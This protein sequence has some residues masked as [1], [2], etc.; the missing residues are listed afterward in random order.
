MPLN[1]GD[2]MR[3]LMNVFL[4]LSVGVAT[5]TS[6][7]FRSSHEAALG[8]GELS[9]RL[10]FDDLDND[11]D[12]LV[13][14]KDSDCCWACLPD[15]GGDPDCRGEDWVI[16]KILEEDAAYWVAHPEEDAAL[17]SAYLD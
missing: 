2:V 5:V 4:F 16:K 8:S 1:G 11:G 12:G 9:D 15:C 17:R 10:C 14:C 3:K 7:D 13:D 6:C